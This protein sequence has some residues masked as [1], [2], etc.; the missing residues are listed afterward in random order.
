MKKKQDKLEKRTIAETEL[1][2]AIGKKIQE[3]RKKLGLSALRIS[4]ELKISREAVTHI[5]NGRNNITA[6]ALW[7]LA[8][9][10]KCDIQD[11]FPTMPDGYALTRL[12]VE[13]VA[14]EDEKAAEW[15]EILFK[16]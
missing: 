7:E 10:F 14:Q 16:K 6:V 2:K 5:E 9:L 13:K 3:M 12:D 4:E 1:R 8:T 15:A 11:F